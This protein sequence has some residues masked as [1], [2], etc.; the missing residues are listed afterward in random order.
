MMTGINNLNKQRYLTSIASSNLCVCNEPNA[1][2]HEFKGD[3]AEGKENQSETKRLT[4][5]RSLGVHTHVRR[6]VRKY[7]STLASMHAR[8]NTDLPHTHIYTYSHTSMHAYTRA[9]IDTLT[10]T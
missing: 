6:H 7:R 10:R 8:T 3:H 5:A 4:S 1:N 9:R 2:T